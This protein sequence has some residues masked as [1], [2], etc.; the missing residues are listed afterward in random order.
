[1]ITSP[2]VLKQPKEYTLENWV[3]NPPEKKEWVDG[4]L[5]DKNAMTLKHKSDSRKSLLLLEK[6][7]RF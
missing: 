5:L 3:Q 7:Q 4:E 6:L 1:M 2:V